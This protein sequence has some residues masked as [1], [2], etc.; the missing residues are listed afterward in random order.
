MDEEVIAAPPIDDLQ[1]YRPKGWVL[2][3]RGAEFGVP[4]QNI[5]VV[6]IDGSYVVIEHSNSS[7]YMEYNHA[8]EAQ[9]NFRSVMRSIQIALDE[10]G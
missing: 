1:Q 9:K 2:F 3:D 4:V 5:K 10:M 6:K 7:W 8:E